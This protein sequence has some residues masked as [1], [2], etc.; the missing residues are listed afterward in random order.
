MRTRVRLRNVR[1][2]LL[3]AKIHQRHIKRAPLGPLRASAVQNGRLYLRAV[4]GVRAYEDVT[5]PLTRT[6]CN[7]TPCTVRERRNKTSQVFAVE[8]A[9]TFAQKPNLPPLAKY[10]R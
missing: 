5:Q 4:E 9:A 2:E 3:R 7:N 8:T 6:H 1:S 10:K